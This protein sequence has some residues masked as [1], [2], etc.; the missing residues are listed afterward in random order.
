MKGWLDCR[1][2]GLSTGGKL[3]YLHRGKL[4]SLSQLFSKDQRIIQDLKV[5]ILILKFKRWDCLIVSYIIS[6]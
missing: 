4:I 2:C 6:S 5:D 3:E 1:M